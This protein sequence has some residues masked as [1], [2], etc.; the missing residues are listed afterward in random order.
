[1]WRKCF[2]PYLLKSRTK[3]RTRLC[4]QRPVNYLF[5]QLFSSRR[6]CEFRSNVPKTVHN[7]ILSVRPVYYGAHAV[8]C[9]ED[10]PHRT[11]GPETYKNAFR[12]LMKVARHVRNLILYIHII[13]TMQFYIIS[14]S[15][16]DFIMTLYAYIIYYNNNIYPTLRSLCS[17]PPCVVYIGILYNIRVH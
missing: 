9:G 10:H 14:H 3:A 1:M 2:F 11:F 15:E 17:S 16:I 7:I 8:P 5:S 12:I 4:T 13:Y 6:H